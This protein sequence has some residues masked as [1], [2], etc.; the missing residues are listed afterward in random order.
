MQGA[1]GVPLTGFSTITTHSH[2]SG[3]L[4]QLTYITVRGVAGWPEA[5]GAPMTFRQDAEL[6][7]DNILFLG[8]MYEAL[9]R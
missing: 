7:G 8:I 5:N 9:A 4:G 1:L 6:S 2:R 3:V